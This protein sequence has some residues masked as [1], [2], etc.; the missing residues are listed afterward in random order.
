M[1]DPS[2]L[3]HRV[4]GKNFINWAEPV[5]GSQVQ[6]SSNDDR[7]TASVIQELV[8]RRNACVLV[9]SPDEAI[10]LSDRLTSGYRSLIGPIHCS[11]FEQESLPAS[12]KA[13]LSQSKRRI[14]INAQAL[15]SVTVVTDSDNAAT[16]GMQT[17]LEACGG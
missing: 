17:A 9:T 13:N 2:T 12:V 16:I 14:Y 6:I 3:I 1:L 7:L 10:A 4:V 15:P 11:V 8:I 5:T